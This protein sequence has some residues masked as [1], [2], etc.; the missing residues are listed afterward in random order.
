MV[1]LARKNGFTLIE[2]LVVIAIIAILIGLLLPAVQKVREAAARMKCSNNLKQIALAAHN[3]HDSY[4][5]LPSTQYMAP[6][7]SPILPNPLPPATNPTTGRGVQPMFDALSG[8]YQ[9]LPYI[10]QSALRTQVYDAMMGAPGFGPNSP[11]N[12]GPWK[13]VISTYQCPSDGSLVLDASGW[14]PRNYHMIVGDRLDANF[15]RQTVRGVFRN[16][17][18]TGGGNNYN[19]PEFHGLT[20]LQITDGTSN[21]VM[22]S[23]RKRPVSGNDIGRVGISTA[24]P[25]N[26]QAQWNGTQYTS[27]IAGGTTPWTPSGRWHD[28]RSLFGSIYTILPPNSPNCTT[29]ST[30]N[31]DGRGFFSASSNHTGGVMVAFADGSIRFIRSSIDTGDLSRNAT[32]PANFNGASPYG[33]WGAMGTSAG[34]EVISADN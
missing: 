20:L 18:P 6:V 14:G 19:A 23:E 5:A 33:V 7:G 8:F 29:Q 11:A 12:W 17:N 28:G 16:F 2:L 27:A 26:C 34:G 32:D 30:A 4:G 22:F 1:R 25:N 21:T 31:G 13:T 24:V 9:L 10:E 15:D 3:H